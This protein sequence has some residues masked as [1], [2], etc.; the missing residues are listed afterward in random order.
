M[1]FSCGC[2][3]KD[4]LRRDHSVPLLLRSLLETGRACFPLLRPNRIND[5]YPLNEISSLCL[6]WEELASASRAGLSDWPAF[7]SHCRY[8]IISSASS[9]CVWSALSEW[10]ARA[11]RLRTQTDWGALIQ[12][13]NNAASVSL[14]GNEMV[15]V[16]LYGPSWLIAF[17]PR[18]MFDAG[19]STSQRSTELQSFLSVAP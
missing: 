16:S 13:P 18:L 19:A 2:R 3:P 12:Q 11:T 15:P 8:L 14:G 7:T 10:T 5:F 1:F 6:W 17:L 4:L 9:S